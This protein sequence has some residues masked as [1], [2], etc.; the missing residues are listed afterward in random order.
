MWNNRISRNFFKRQSNQNY[1]IWLGGLKVWMWTNVA[2]H[3]YTTKW[4]GA[5]LDFFY[6][7]NTCKNQ[8]RP[9]PLI[10]VSYSVLHVHA[11]DHTWKLI[12]H[13][14]RSHRLI[15]IHRVISTY[16][17]FLNCFDNLILGKC[18][19]GKG[20]TRYSTKHMVHLTCDFS[21]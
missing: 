10:H 9:K 6:N 11:Y 2:E 1:N 12:I 16:K 4:F 7:L 15:I 13:V 8:P 18:T 21:M 17:I 19:D 5:N 14:F 20:T 3:N